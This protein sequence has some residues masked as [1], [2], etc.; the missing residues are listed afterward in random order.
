[1][2]AISQTTFS[3]VFSWMKIVD[4][5]ADDADDNIYIYI[6]IY[7]YVHRYNYLNML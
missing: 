2:D 3:S 6:F 4:F 5:D 7:E 1:M